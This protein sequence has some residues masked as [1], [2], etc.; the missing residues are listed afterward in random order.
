MSFLI[1]F[2]ETLGTL[3]KNQMWLQTGEGAAIETW[4]KWDGLKWVKTLINQDD[5][6][7]LHQITVNLATEISNTA[8]QI[9]LRATKEEVDE[10]RNELTQQA[11]QIT[12]TAEQLSIEVSRLEGDI[13][14]TADEIATVKTYFDFSEEG[15]EIGKTNAPTTIVIDNQAMQFLD[16][17]TEGEEPPEFTPHPQA[18]AWIHGRK[19][20]IDSLDVLTSM[21]IGSH[22]IEKYDEKTTIIRWVG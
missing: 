7:D 3:P 22:K 9:T 5:I 15:L 16:K 17:S 11:T 12:T 18:V 21:V 13:D 10:V 19:M 6:N 4:W 20:L 14:A 1:T 2:N 8:E